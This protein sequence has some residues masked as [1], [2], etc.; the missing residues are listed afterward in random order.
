MSKLLS[1]LSLQSSGMN[2]TRVNSAVALIVIDHLLV[3]S[4]SAHILPYAS[5]LTGLVFTYAYSKEE[6]KRLQYIS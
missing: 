1:D 4:Q 6:G 5:P 3:A 2:N